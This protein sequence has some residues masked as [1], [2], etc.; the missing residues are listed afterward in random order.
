MLMVPVTVE[1][2]S[3]TL[4]DDDD[5]LIAGSQIVTPLPD[6]NAMV[7]RDPSAATPIIDASTVRIAWRDLKVRIG[8]PLAG[9]TVKWSM[10]PRFVPTQEDGTPA[11]VPSFRGRWG[12]AGND[13]Y[14]NRFSDSGNYGTHG[15][16]K[17]T[18][19]LEDR[20]FA[21]VTTEC[22]TQIDADG[23][24]AIRVNLP[25][26]GFNKA[27]IAMYIDPAGLNIPM[28]LID[29]EVP[30]VVVID[31]GHGG[32]YSAA[33]HS[34]WKISRFQSEQRNELWLSNK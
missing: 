20:T 1:E 18:E 16:L 34:Q 32:G 5:H 11:A 4:C 19:E 26:I 33:R 17:W 2:L 13:A 27:R 9:K 23:Y 25:P 14:R 8:E 3:P 30:A 21:M 22:L 7:E 6:C 31:P 28:D 10:T 15:Y 29:L 24:T 12:T